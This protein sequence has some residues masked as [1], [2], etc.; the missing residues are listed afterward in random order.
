MD[1]PTIG[2]ID[3][4]GQEISKFTDDQLAVFRRKNCGFVFQQIYIMDKMSLMSNGK[5]NILLACVTMIVTFIIVAIVLY[6]IIK[7]VITRKKVDFGILKAVGYTTKQLKYQM[8]L[9]LAPVVFIGATLGGVFSFI[10]M[11]EL[12]GILF[13]VIG[14]MKLAFVVPLILVLGVVIVIVVIAFLLAV[15]LS[16][17]IRKI[18]A[19][20]LMK[21]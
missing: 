21:D 20:S 19:Y 2:K 9:S 12:I 10:F 6:M 3:F 8:A 13:Q 17:R 11:N 14:I 4:L 18:S 1:K 5:Q 7:T 16:G 15:A